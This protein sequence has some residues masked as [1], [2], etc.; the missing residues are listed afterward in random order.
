MHR[1]EEVSEVWAEPENQ[2]VQI[3]PRM[4]LD[5]A[6]TPA[7]K[8]SRAAA[9][10]G[11]GCSNALSFQIGKQPRQVALATSAAKKQNG[12]PTPQSGNTSVMQPTEMELP[13][14]LPVLPLRKYR[15][16][17]LPGAEQAA[18][19]RIRRRSSAGA[20][21]AEFKFFRSLR[22]PDPPRPDL[23]VVPCHKDLSI[24]GLSIAY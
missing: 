20:E 6:Y 22:N 16:D 21:A 17:S 4:P 14:S 18:E 24:S 2:S 15:K 10:R 13:A 1:G 23:P 11:P 19:K 8:S 7:V 12:S 5:C 3:S 9:E